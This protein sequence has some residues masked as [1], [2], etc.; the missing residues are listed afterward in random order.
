MKVRR[1][2]IE[3]KPPRLPYQIVIDVECLGDHEA[4]RTHLRVEGEHLPSSEYCVHVAADCVE[5]YRLRQLL[6]SIAKAARSAD[7]ATG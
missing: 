4:L 1:Q 6:S 2:A 3:P 5:R 7:D